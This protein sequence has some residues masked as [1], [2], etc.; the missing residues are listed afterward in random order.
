M[1]R[2]I[3]RTGRWEVLSAPLMFLVGILSLTSSLRGQVLQIGE[4]TGVVGKEVALPIIVG[5]TTFAVGDTVR[6]TG[7]M[8]LANPTVWFPQ[9]IRVS[10]GALLLEQGIPIEVDSLRDFSVSLL[11]EEPFTTGDTLAVVAGE[12]VAGSDTI[13]GLF[14]FD[15]RLGLLSLP[16]QTTTV[17]TSAL[18]PRLFYVRFGQL[19]PG[20]PNPT[21]PGQTVTW[22]FR[23]DRATPVIF[24]IYDALG[25]MIV[26][27]DLGFLEKG[28][29]RHAIT[30]EVSTP[31]GFFIVHLA[32]EI[33]DDYEVMHVLH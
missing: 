7:T 15:L 23:I 22:G 13:T 5:D 19:D 6:L 26:F 32:T 1:T 3:C 12:G 14:L 29:Y 20:R 11:C 24:R 31:S 16:S 10:S 30:P 33:G 17:T 18:G 8:K 25:R 9:Q 27:D 21:V 28:V 4:G 2:Q